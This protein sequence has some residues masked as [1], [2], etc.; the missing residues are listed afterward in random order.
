MFI[1]HIRIKKKLLCLKEEKKTNF[2]INIDLSA[3]VCD[4]IDLVPISRIAE[5]R[6]KIEEKKANIVLINN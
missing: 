6:R 5:K 2:K 1:K 4:P 3:V